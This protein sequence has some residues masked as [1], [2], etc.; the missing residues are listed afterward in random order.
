MAFEGGLAAVLVGLM[1]LLFLRDW[2]SVVVVVL[3]IPLALI[4]S[5]VALALTGQT[6]NLMTLGG[7]AL[8]VGILVDE[9]TVEVE[10][11]H[12]QMEKT[13]SIALAVRRGNA[14]TAVP[15]LLAMLCILAVFIP[16]F[17][18]QGSARGLFVP[19]SLAVGFAMIASYLLSST[20][21]PV[22]SVWLLRKHHQR[23][24]AADQREPQ[25]LL[26]RGVRRPARAHD[27]LRGG[28]SCRPTWS[29]PLLATFFLGRLLG[30]EIFPQ[31][32]A[33]QFQFRLRAP[34]GTRIEQTEEITREALDFIGKEVG[35]ENV[36]D[37]PRLR[38]RGAVQ[39]PDQQRLPVDGR[40]GGGGD[41]R[42]PEAR[43]GARRGAEA[44][45]ARE[46]AGPSAGVG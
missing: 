27:A 16:S 22:L 3:N 18:M 6:I 38:R 44:A 34:D 21:V 45:P 33:G 4:G 7:L 17:F 10:N 14:E 2:R 32:D 30:T 5:V 43:R 37:H 24:E 12:T 9:A 26:V 35:P 36:D 23:H 42:R 28:W 39:L 29:R 31:V 1:V 11:I 13:D 41:A 19:L 46:A 40:P 25:S 20:F 15:R 8:A